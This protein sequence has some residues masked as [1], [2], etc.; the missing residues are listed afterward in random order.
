VDR[1]SQ[2][3]KWYAIVPAA[4]A[5]VAVAVPWLIARAPEMG[6]ALQRGFAL[7]CHQRAERSFFLFGGSVAVCARCLGIYLGAVAG[8][9]VCVPRPIAWR[10]LIAAVS[11]NAIDWLAELGGMHSNWTAARFALGIALG[12]AASMLVAARSDEHEIPM[13]AKEA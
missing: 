13:H 5:V 10:W 12:V 8:L 4:L 2:I 3:E 6:F 7:V 11:I 1:K 9:L